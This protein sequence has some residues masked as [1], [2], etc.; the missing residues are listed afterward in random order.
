MGHL[1]LV[2]E[3]DEEIQEFYALMLEEIDC[4]ILRAY[5]GL[6]AL[7]RL[8]EVLPDLIV[9]DILLDEMM[10]DQFLAEMRKDPRYADIPVVIASVLSRERCHDLLDQD[11]RTVYL[12]K[13]FGKGDLLAAVRAGLAQAATID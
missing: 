12:R 11:L 10:G 5:D 9:L 7:D 8:E 6:E 13:P 1:V 2:V 4:Q 3:D